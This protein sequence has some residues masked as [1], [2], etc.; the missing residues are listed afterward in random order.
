M[1]LGIQM[2]AVIMIRNAKQ[3][4]RLIVV[5][6]ETRRMK[7]P[8]MNR[9]AKIV[10]DKYQLQLGQREEL[11]MSKIEG[12]R[13]SEARVLLTHSLIC[14]FNPAT[15]LFNLAFSFLSLAASS[16]LALY[17]RSISSPTLPRRTLLVTFSNSSLN[18]A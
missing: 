10:T 9:T 15:S 2:S 12:V 13:W 4:I 5:T 7:K 1:C 8:R 16:S 3:A 17:R 6:A 11:V 14:A 18:R